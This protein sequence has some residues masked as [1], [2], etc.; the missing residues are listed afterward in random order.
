MRSRIMIIIAAL[1][2][3]GLAAV[4]AATYLNSAR[5]RLDAQSEPVEVLV[6]QEEIPRGTSAEDLF[7][8][9][10]VTTQKIPRQFI[11]AGAISSQRA[12]DGQVL[13]VGLS[14][15]EQ[16]TS[17]RFQYPSQA[18]IAYSVPANYV[19]LSIAVDKVTS[20]SGL[21]RPG[22]QVMVIG[23]VASGSKDKPAVSTKVLVPKARVLAVGSDSGAGS[24]NQPT[25]QQ[26]GGLMGAAGRTQADSTVNAVT[27][28]VS[29]SDAERIVYVANLGEGKGDRSIWCALLPVKTTTVPATAGRSS[30]NILAR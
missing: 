1:V 20:V 3:G 5:V 10:L 14:Q 26:A 27:V 29:P 17:G 8:K 4:M 13:S 23:T 19:A 18:G 21:L 9:K 11:A 25:T 22:D 7:T 6:A 30:M 2:L 16:L 28:A 24:Q 12:L 15:G